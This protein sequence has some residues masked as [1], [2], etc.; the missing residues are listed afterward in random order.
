[1]RIRGAGVPADKSARRREQDIDGTRERKA[2]RNYPE[3]FIL[4]AVVWSNNDYSRES[5]AKMI[6]LSRVPQEMRQLVSSDN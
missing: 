4:L 2:S 5:G 3:G 1:M 6:V